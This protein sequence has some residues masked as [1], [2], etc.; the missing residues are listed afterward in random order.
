MRWGRWAQLSSLT[1]QIVLGSTST[2]PRAQELEWVKVTYLEPI[3]NTT[4]ET[5]TNRSTESKFGPTHKKNPRQYFKMLIS[6]ENNELHGIF[7]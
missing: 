2:H 3:L 1:S 4:F 5:R 7:Q 6:L